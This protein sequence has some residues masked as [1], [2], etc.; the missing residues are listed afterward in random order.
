MQV[1]VLLFNAGTSNEGIHTLKVSDR[2]IVLMFEHED[3]AVRY[4]LMLEA[5]DFGSPT[6]EAF[7]SDDIEE[8]CLGAGYECKHIPTGTLEV[9]PDANAPSTDWQPDGTAQPEPVN[10]EGEF[11]ADELERLRKRLEGLL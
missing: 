11:S 4:S 8:F 7:E 9:P 3:D 5:Q 1:F 10:Q 2:N 6:V